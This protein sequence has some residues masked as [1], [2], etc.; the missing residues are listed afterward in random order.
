MAAYGFREYTLTGSGQPEAVRTIPVT[1]GFFSVLRAQPLLGRVFLDSEDQPG[2]DQEVVLSNEF[3]R[4]H[5]SSDRQIVGKNI[6][7]NGEA[8]TVVGVMRPDFQFPIGTDPANAPQMWKPAGWS[9]AERTIRDNHNY[10]VIARLKPG[11]TLQQAKAELEH[12]REPTGTAVSQRR[13]GLG[14]DRNSHARGPGG[15]RAPGA[16]DPAGRSGVRA[17]DR[18]R[19][20]REPGAGEDAFAQEG[21]RHPKRAG[22]QPTSPAATGIVRNGSAGD[23]R[24][25]AGAHLRALRHHADCEVPGAA[26]CPSPAA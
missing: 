6:D 24:R 10:L 13:Q 19:Q 2:H 21:S 22:R 26:D 4:T 7:L 1:A 20:R 16:A 11:V 9:A 25:R 23:C 8:F 18:V 15:R 17:A 3:W 12:H 5:F 14:R